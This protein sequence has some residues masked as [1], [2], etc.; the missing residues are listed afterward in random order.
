VPDFVTDSSMPA[1]DR[2]DHYQAAASTAFAPLRIT[3]ADMS[4]FAGHIRNEQAGNLLVADIRSAPVTVRRTPKLITSTD[5]EMYK[6][7][8]HVSGTAL[9]SQDGRQHEMSP[10]DLVIYDTTRPYTLDYSDDYRTIV[11]GCPRHHLA[12]NA[13]ALAEVTATP[14]ATGSGI[15]RLV[16][17]FFTGLANELDS[18]V[19]EGGVHL[20]DS[21]LDMVVMAFLGPDNRRPGTRS[22]LLDRVI[23]H[24]EANLADPRLSVHTVAKAHGVSAR[25]L[26]KVFASQDQTLAAWIRTRRLDRIRRDLENPRLAGRAV[27]AIAARW[28]LLDAANFSRL[29]RSTYGISP[30]EYRRHAMTVRAAVG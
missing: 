14:V 18:N 12:P 17:G 28:G 11:I 15:R 26:H 21:L 8:L 9:I 2:L 4:G 22:T 1:G 25:Y 24:C 19:E 27:S 16:A 30:S 20:A 23:A 29:F 7:A 13:D 10:G 5:N 6:V 3:P